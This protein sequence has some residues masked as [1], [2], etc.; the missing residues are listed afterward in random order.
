[1]E[2][3][4]YPYAAHPLPSISPTVPTLIVPITWTAS[5]NITTFNRLFFSLSPINL[6]NNTIKIVYNKSYVEF[7]YILYYQHYYQTTCLLSVLKVS[8]IK[9]P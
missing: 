4:V 7:Y 3:V 2:V 8:W 5:F 9:L 1:M 6:H